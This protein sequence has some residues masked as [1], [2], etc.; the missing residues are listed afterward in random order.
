MPADGS[1]VFQS[2]AV[3]G[4]EHVFSA[5]SGGRGNKKKCKK[6]RG[7]GTNH[8]G[9]GSDHDDD[10]DR[11]DDDDHDHGRNGRHGRCGADDDSGDEDDPGGGVV[12]VGDGED[13]D[14]DGNGD[15]PTAPATE[16]DDDDD[17]DGDSDGNGDDDPEPEQQAASW[18]APYWR[19]TGGFAVRP[20]DGRSAV[21]HLECGGNT[22][23]TEEYAGEDGLIVRTVSQSACTDQEGKPVEGELTFEGIDGDGWYWINGERN[24]ALAP[25]VSDS[26]VS[27]QVRPPVP[28]GVTASPSGDKRF[29]LSVQGRLR[30][31]LMVHD[32]TGFMGIVPHLVDLEGAGEHMAPYWKGGGGVV[33]RPLDGESATFHLTCGEGETESYLLEPGE[34]GIIVE[35]LPGCYDEDDQPI[36]GELQADG[37]ED[38]AWYWLNAGK[39][40]TGTDPEPPERCTPEVCSTLAP[41]VRRDSVRDSLTVPLTPAG[42]QAD[43]GPIGTMFSRDSLRGIVP[44]VRN[45]K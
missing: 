2:A 39:R 21:A 38:G 25:L 18:L 20:A 15:F 13:D 30:G 41:L 27:R 28:A 29:V 12:F 32:T 37:L 33:G 7:H 8:H 1:A 45:P 9:D 17:D 43:E 14:D 5:H 19:G 4:A 24:V 42:V 11:D 35:L 31:T 16:S 40:F 36:E 34:D 10:D 44:R 26:S 6:K 3:E 22:Y 23:S